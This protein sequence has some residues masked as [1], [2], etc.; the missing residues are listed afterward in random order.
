[1]GNPYATA[2]E[3]VILRCL[4]DEPK[5]LYGLE[6]VRAARGEISRGSVYTLLGRLEDKGFVQSRIKRD[7]DHG[8][9]PRPRY[10]LTAL[11][12]LALDAAALMGLHTAKA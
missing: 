12:G 3:L 9:L 11:G 6:I 5:G 7:A 10:T 4:K 2:T 8:G 1:M